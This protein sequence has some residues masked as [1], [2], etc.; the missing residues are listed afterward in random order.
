MTY[1]E[2]MSEIENY[3]TRLERMMEDINSGDVSSIVK[4]VMAAYEQGYEEG[5]YDGYGEGY[6]E[7]YG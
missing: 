7:A 6:E 1:K 4:W 3:S 2:W 5:H